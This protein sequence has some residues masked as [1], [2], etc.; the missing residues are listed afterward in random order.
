MGDIWRTT[1]AVIVVIGRPRPLPPSMRW[2]TAVGF[3]P[4]LDSPDMRLWL[5]RHLDPEGPMEAVFV[6]PVHVC[7]PIVMQLPHREV[8]VPA[9]EYTLFTTALAP[10]R[11][12]PIGS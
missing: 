12:P 2:H 7:P 4:S 6:V 8:C 5:H 10:P 1:H 3:L 9:G 11:P